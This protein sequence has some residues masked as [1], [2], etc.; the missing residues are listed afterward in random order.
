[1]TTMRVR[2]HLITLIT[3][4]VRDL[5]KLGTDRAFTAL[6][7][8]FDLTGFID[9]LSDSSCERL[10]VAIVALA[11]TL[12][13][14]ELIGVAHGIVFHRHWRGTK[15]YD[16]ADAMACEAVRACGVHFV[17][18]NQNEDWDVTMSR[19]VRK[20]EAGIEFQARAA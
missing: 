13:A 2:E 7:K 12:D 18:P 5:V 20:L 11:P 15:T 19:A 9:N 4:N 14:E 6:D 16:R 3:E 1:M 10:G 8:T 17:R